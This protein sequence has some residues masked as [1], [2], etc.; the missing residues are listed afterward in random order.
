[1]R[2]SLD[3]MDHQSYVKPEFDAEH[4]YKIFKE[5]LYDRND[6]YKKNMLRLQKISKA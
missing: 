2:L 1:M 4:V 6:Y 5:V 3:N